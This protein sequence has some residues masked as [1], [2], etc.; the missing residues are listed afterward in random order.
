MRAGPADFTAPH[1]FIFIQK[2]DKTPSYPGVMLQNGPIWV[3]QGSSQYSCV[4]MFS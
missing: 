3:W 1:L 4:I 2:S